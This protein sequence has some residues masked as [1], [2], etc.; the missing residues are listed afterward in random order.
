MAT[1]SRNT[2]TSKAI[3]KK[4][5]GVR[6]AKITFVAVAAMQGF[7]LFVNQD[8]ETLASVI[9]VIIFGGALFAGVAY[10]IGYISGK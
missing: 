7:R 6:Y 4:E 2:N 9:V 10:V 1:K 8:A 5:Q 3:R